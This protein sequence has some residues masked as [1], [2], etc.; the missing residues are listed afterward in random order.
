VVVCYF[1]Q[2]VGSCLLSEGKL[3]EEEESEEDQLQSVAE[4]E[5]KQVAVDDVP[6]VSS[7]SFLELRCEA[8][9]TDLG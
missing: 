1:E 3:L 8:K 6:K 5:P 2:V 4:A 9:R 7:P